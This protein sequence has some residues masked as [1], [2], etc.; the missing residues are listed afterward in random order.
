MRNVA[1]LIVPALLA[2]AVT[3]GHAQPADFSGTWQLDRDASV[4]PEVPRGGRGIGR[5][6]GRGGQA[7]RGPSETLVITQTADALFVEQRSDDDARILRYRLDG[8]SSTNPM[9]RGELTTTSRW[10]GN[11][12]V[13]EGTQEI[14][15]PLRD[16]SMQLT[17]R[18]SLS[19]DGRTMTVESTRT[20]RRGEIKA[21]LV[22]RR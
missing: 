20:T 17:E 11:T 1:L 3:S 18:R 22:Y 19:P 9:P 7:P 13:T 15:R 21:T 8:S 16:I 6:F 14:P 12:V 5:L 2:A 4:L 10:D